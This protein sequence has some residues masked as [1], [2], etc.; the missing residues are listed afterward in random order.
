MN[1]IA[2]PWIVMAAAIALLPGVLGAQSSDERTT[3]P[4]IATLPAEGRALPSFEATLLDGSSFTTESLQGRPAIL[5]LWSADCPHSRAIKPLL[6]ELQEKALAEGSHFLVAN[7]TE[8]PDR[9][10]AALEGVPP[11]HVIQ[12]AGVIDRFYNMEAYEDLGEDVQKA[13]LIPAVIVL[14]EMGI[15]RHSEPWDGVD[16]AIALLRQLRTMAGTAAM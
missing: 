12:V 10:R 6:V 16:A 14:D 3:R 5:I 8:D 7:I 15:V 2:R 13:V 11:R 4:L 1:R 9:S